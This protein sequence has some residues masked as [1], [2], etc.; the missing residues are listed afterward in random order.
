MKRLFALLLCGLMI[1]ST[2]VLAIEETQTVE[3]LNLSKKLEK[4]TPTNAVNVSAENVVIL[5]YNTLEAAFAQDFSSKIARVGDNITFIIQKDL[6]TQEGTLVI[7][8]STKINGQI[9]QIEKPK[10]FNKSGKIYID[11]Q[12]MEF[13]DGKVLPIQ[14]RLFDK[15]EFLSR[16]KLN[17]LGKGLGSTLGG[18]AVGTAAGCGIGIAAN[19]VIIGGFAIGMPVGLAVGAA[20]GLITPGLYYKAKSGD[21]INIQI[22]NNL[23]IER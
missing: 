5:P 3:H 1:S 4:K 21:K 23:T 11:F 18:M 14:A 6:K 22:M 17:A 8:E 12:D 10:L 16:G 19:A 13:P 7:P 2:S 20:A 9:T 15:K